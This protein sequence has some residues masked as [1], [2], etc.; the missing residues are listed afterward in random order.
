MIAG[1][2]LQYASPFAALRERRKRVTPNFFVAL[3]WFSPQSRYSEGGDATDR[4]SDPYGGVQYKGVLSPNTNRRSLPIKYF[5]CSY[6]L[7]VLIA[8]HT[9]GSEFGF[10]DKC[11]VLL[12]IDDLWFA[13]KILLF[14]CR[15]IRRATGAL[16]YPRVSVIVKLL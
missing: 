9:R 4:G 13:R 12:D 5:V 1:A 3:I 6:R 15:A 8:C 7:I 2:R 16:G 10:S 14:E 11:R